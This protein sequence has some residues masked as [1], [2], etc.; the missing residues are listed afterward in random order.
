MFFLCIAILRELDGETLKK[1]LT[2]IKYK[3]IS[4]LRSL[5]RWKGGGPL[6]RFSYLF[7]PPKVPSFK[8]QSVTI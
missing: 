1:S 2:F 6:K 4:Y 5:K 8:R 7:N 3:G